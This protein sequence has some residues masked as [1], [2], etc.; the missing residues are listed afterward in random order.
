MKEIQQPPSVSPDDCGVSLLGENYDSLPLQSLLSTEGKPDQP[1]LVR[2]G[3][4][5]VFTSDGRDFFFISNFVKKN[6]I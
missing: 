4:R 2:M 6:I 3:G 1:L 5:R